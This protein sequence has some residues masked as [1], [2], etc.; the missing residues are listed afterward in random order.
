MA[1][2]TADASASLAGLALRLS[3][4]FLAGKVN[5][6]R[7]PVARKAKATDSIWYGG[8]RPKY[9]GTFSSATPSDLT[10]EYPGDCGWDTA[11]LFDPG[12]RKKQK[13]IEEFQPGSVGAAKCSQLTNG[14]LSRSG[15]IYSYEQTKD[16]S[17]QRTQTS[18]EDK[19]MHRKMLE[20]NLSSSHKVVGGIESRQLN[21]DS[22]KVELKRVGDIKAH[23]TRSITVNGVLEIR[24]LE[25]LS[26]DEKGQSPPISEGR[27]TRG[28]RDWSQ[29]TTQR[30]GSM[31]MD[32][33]GITS[34]AIAFLH[35]RLQQG[36][37]TGSGL[38]VKVLQ[39]CLKQNDLLATKQ[40]HDCIIQ[41]GM[42]KIPIVAGTLMNVYIKCGALVDARRVFDQLE[43]KSV[44]DWTIMI[45][46]YAKSD[47][48]ESALELFNQMRQ[49]GVET[50][51]ITYLSILKACASPLALTLGK[52]IHECIRHASLESD[53]FIGTALIK[54]YATC[55]CIAEARQ[56]FDRL[57]KRDVVAWTV[58]IGGLAQNGCGHEAYR[59]FLKMKREGFE[60]NAFTFASIL[61]AS[62][63]TGALEW[64]QEVHCHARKAGLES[65]LRVGNALV[66]MYA[67][68]GSIDDARVVFDRMEKRDVVTWNV[69]I[70]GLAQHGCGHEAYRLFCQMRRAGFEPNAVTY[71]SILNAS[72]SAGALDWVKEVHGDAS[73]VGLESDVRVGNALVH[74][75]AKSGSIDDARGVFDRM[76][77]R[78]VVTWNAMIGGLAQHGCGHEALEYFRKMNADNLKP[79]QT[80][81]VAVLSAC[82]HAG[83]VDDGRRLF[84]AMKQDYGI[85]PN[86]MHY[87]CMVDLLG[88]AGNLEEAKLFISNMPVEAT[89]VTWTA[90]LG[91]CRTYGNVE[92]GEL[93]AKKLFKLEPDNASTYV[94]LSNIYGAAGKWEKQVLVRTMMEERGL[95]KEPGRSWIEVDKKIHEFVV[96]D[97][98]HPEAKEIYTMLKKMTEKL[99]AGGY[100]PDT[101]LVLHN[102]DEADK[103]LALCSHSEKLAIAY[104][105]MR[106]PRGEPIR[107][108]KNLR[109]CSDCHAA[110]KLISKMTGREI[111]VRDTIRFH[112]FT[113]GVCSCGDYW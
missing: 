113:D 83:R 35:S 29:D 102:I 46:E 32:S 111:L 98:S 41:S 87:T 66:H 105:L 99:K 36:I 23:L 96:G 72:G 39:T 12:T 80:T 26:R 61:N 6:G 28:S 108:Y 75:Y 67:K 13:T 10:A 59:L 19:K 70:G 8:H 64:V 63:S 9:L 58:M 97:F 93:A 14:R 33:G 27:V 18:N 45:A 100:T 38:Y 31:H 104:G 7:G 109:V 86:I 91:A 71:L 20:H 101:R 5:V 88:R 82:C 52:Q 17:Y 53:V 34:Q 65:D 2:S 51:E 76:E 60:P 92:L 22:L 74:M 62:A 1:G 84:L 42:D 25:L 103:E 95:R 57:E 110:T 89:G 78:D 43:T 15:Y 3:K 73:K 16:Y 77:K 49:E 54:M 47:H 21:T 11:G 68:S 40:V 81:F 50:D 69:M 44:V 79:D 106:I 90:L 112:L 24:E 37:T 55:G 85:E 107:V 48:A 56:V 4:N 30:N 94:L